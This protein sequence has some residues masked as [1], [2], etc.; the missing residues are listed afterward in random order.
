MALDERYIPLTSLN[1]YFVDKDSG[2]PLAAGTIESYQDTS[3]SD[4]K[5]LYELVSSGGEYS[6]SALPNPITLSAA[7][8]V[9]NA[10]GVN[11]IA[12]AYP[13]GEDAASGELVIDR[14]YLVCKN[15]AGTEQWTREAVP[16]LTDANDPVS[17]ES[18]SGNQLSNAQFSRYFLPDSSQSLTVSSTNQ[19]FPISPDWT[20]V[21]SGSGTVTIVRT[22]VSGNNAIPTYPAYYLS[23][24]P[25]AGVTEVYLRQRL[26][27]NSGIWS[28]NFVSGFI[29]AKVASGNNALSM[30]YSD[31]AGVNTDVTIFDASLTTSWAEY[32]GSAEIP[33]SSN[34]QSASTAYVDIKL[35]LPL[36]NT[37]DFTSVQALATDSELDGDIQAYDKRTSNREQALMADYYIPELEYKHAASLLQGWDFAV[38]PAQFAATTVSVGT[39]TA[40]YVWDQTILQTS[41]L[42]TVDVTRNAISEGI[43]LNHGVADQSYALIQYLDNKDAAKFLGSPLSVNI[44]GFTTDGGN[45]A[46]TTALKVY[47]FANADDTKFGTLPTSLV[48]LSTD[49]TVAL[50]TQASTTDGWYEI[51]RSNL[52]TATGSLTELTPADIASHP[53]VG[54]TGWKIEDTTQV[55]AGVEAIAIVVSLVPQ[56]SSTDYNTVINSISVVQGNISCR[57]SP[58]SVSSTK[59]LLQ[60]Y[61]EKSY[62]G[63][64]PQT[65]DNMLVAKQTFAPV[66]DSGTAKVRNV[67]AVTFQH[68]YMTEKRAAPTITIY[69]PLTG[70]A[71]RV[72]TYLDNGSGNNT[73]A[74]HT[75]STFWS[76]RNSSTVRVTYERVGSSSILQSSGNITNSGGDAYIQYHYVADSRIGI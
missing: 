33:D 76:V 24:T 38:N 43:N 13:Y 71:D 74:E 44:S 10:S 49:G 9:S 7:G 60:R 34:T 42:A 67:K 6:Y 15:S 64:D 11:V 30:M 73:N 3:R 1:E 16:N 41:T 62:T 23:I 69:N 5:P 27:K 31:S 52:P 39:N 65:L 70:T 36:S 53:D 54:L 50:T 56:A 51:T 46:G 48:T 75:F 25:G 28:G 63:T 55:N 22:A 18:T 40:E 12:Y 68:A 35:E 57:P 59:E 21:A 8:T 26:N 17:D 58:M 47:M 4:A 72:Q 20:L 61:Y 2:L 45:S 19:E 66:D 32:G 37:T 29:V 14:Y